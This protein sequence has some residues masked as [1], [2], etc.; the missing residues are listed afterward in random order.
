MPVTEIGCM[1]VKPGLDVMDDTT[2]AGQIL[3]RVYETVTT[4]PGGPCRVYWGVELKADA[5]EEHAESKTANDDAR[6]TESGL[7]PD[8]PKLWAFFDFD[9]VEHHEKF[10]NG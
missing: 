2:E 4:A 10:A 7:D 8:P 1:G 9:S 6:A 5:E 3:T